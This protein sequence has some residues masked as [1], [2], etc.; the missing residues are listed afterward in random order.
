MSP[1][2]NVNL[3]LQIRLNSAHSSIEDSVH[4]ADSNSS[5]DWLSQKKTN[6]NLIHDMFKAI[7]GQLKHIET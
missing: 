5:K 7:L 3:F 6:W 1:M 4:M 2:K